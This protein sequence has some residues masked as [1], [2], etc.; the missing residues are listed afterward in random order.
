MGQTLE[1]HKEWH[2]FTDRKAPQTCPFCTGEAPWINETEGEHRLIKVSHSEVAMHMRVAGHW[3]LGLDVGN[4]MVQL[5]SLIGRDR[6]TKF[7]FPITK[8]EA[9]WDSPGHT[10]T[11]RVTPIE[12]T[13]PYG[14]IHNRDRVV[15]PH[16]VQEDPAKTMFKE[17]FRVDEKASQEAKAAAWRNS[18]V[19]YPTV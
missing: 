16:E 12:K 18:T 2:A 17:T 9:G 8:G 13:S 1:E 11:Y 4:G 6:P 3:M 5:Y 14:T 15:E 19:A 7:S 10:V